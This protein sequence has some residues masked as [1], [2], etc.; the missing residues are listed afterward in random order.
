M[1]LAGV[2]LAG[3]LL[4]GLSACG[5]HQPAAGSAA[6]PTAPTPAAAAGAAAAGNTAPGSSA[7]AAR[8]PLITLSPDNVHIEYHLFGQGEP[9]VILVHGWACDANYWQA[10]ITP[11]AAHYTVVAVNLA[12]HG[13]SSA[14][15]TD[16]SIA[17][18]AQDVAAVAR[19]IP[20]RQLVLVGHSMG[21]AVAL[22]ATPLL[23]D[24]VIGIVAVEALRSVGEPPL[25]MSE[26]ERRVAP[27]NADFIGA[28]RQ[29]ASDSLFEKGA[30]PL[31]V[32]K[33]AYD[34]SLEPAAVAVPSLRA[35]LATDLTPLL[36]AIHVPVYV[37]NSDL[38]P[39]D[40]ARIRRSLP[41]A[42]VDVLDHSGH[43]L[44]L[45]APARFNPLLLRDL[46]AITQHAAH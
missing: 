8:G 36:A 9:A 25:T 19:Q 26:I 3:V 45:E 17:N 44:M 38:M 15:R 5:Q 40:A 16:W 24:R 11:L 34:M 31:L 32:R 29:L 39:T 41:G 10:Q 7:A 28:T 20:N 46:N 23:G 30:D 12:G 6:A 33:V 35:L 21:A 13:A 1:A 27:F 22:A 37:I 4:A 2:L 18:Y 42:T 14:N 43:F